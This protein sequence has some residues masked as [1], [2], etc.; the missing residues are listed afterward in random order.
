MKKKTAFIVL[1]S[2]LTL[3]TKTT[4][5]ENSHIYRI[6]VIQGLTGVAA[7][8]GQNVLHSVQLAADDINAKGGDQ[9]ELLIQ[10][11]GTVQKNA[12][13]AYEYLKNKNVDAIIGSTW[14]FV[15]N[16]IIPLAAKDKKILLNTS[17]LWES[18]SI[19]QG[20]GYFLNN[21][22]SIEEDV[23]PFAK[24]LELK[25]VTSVALIHTSSRWGT[26]QQEAYGKASLKR[27]AS[28]V[29]DIEP[30]AQEHNQWA[31]EITQLKVKKPEVIALLLNKNDIETILRRASEQGLKTNFFGSKNTY[32]AFRKS[33]NKNLYEGVCF[34]YPYE[35]L[36]KN[37]E[38]T[39]KFEKRYDEAPRVFADN[40][41]DSV[42]ILHQ[43]LKTA[44]ATGENL[45]KVL[46][47]TSFD[48]G[49]SSYSFTK[50]HS[51]ANAKSSLLC[52][53]NGELA[54]R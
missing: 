4:V 45:K 44:Q 24:F 23:K 29:A 5:A 49:L 11:D 21:A 25:N 14:G 27:D 30:L 34:T 13:T 2:I 20:K 39:E 35:Q 36:M 8:D 7:E 15:T 18:F 40:S 52:V 1:I 43:A 26:V 28:V 9:I 42:F 47:T 50:E 38:F 22:I 3:T 48:T 32:D 12:V 46:E 53:E 19:E 51:L 37:K 41:Y 10:D 33:N 17:G 16:A 54:V 6:G 31:T